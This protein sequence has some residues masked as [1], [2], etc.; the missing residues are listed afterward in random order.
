MMNVCVTIIHTQLFL[1]WEIKWGTTQLATE[2]VHVNH[3]IVLWI[4]NKQGFCCFV[5]YINPLLPLILQ[6]SFFE[7]WLLWFPGGLFY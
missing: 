4:A 3:V 6:V 1:W 7:S 5:Y 2:Q